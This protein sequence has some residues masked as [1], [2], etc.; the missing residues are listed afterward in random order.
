MI[1]GSFLTR[2]PGI[3][4]RH[5]LDTSDASS[6][7]SEALRLP[8]S[9]HPGGTTPSWLRPATL[10]GSRRRLVDD[11][12]RSAPNLP[13]ADLAPTASE[14]PSPEGPETLILGATGYVGSC[15]AEALL[16]K[17]ARLRLAGRR[18]GDLERRFPA[19]DVVFSDAMDPTTLRPALRG[20]RTAYYLIHSM[21][22]AKQG[23][24]ERDRHAA[25]NFASAA[26]EAGVE[27]IIYLGGL[28]DPEDDLSHH[29]ASRHETGEMLAEGSTPVLEFRAGIIIGSGS[30]S[31]RMLADLVKRLPVMVTPRWVKT[32]AQPIGIDDVVQYLMAGRAARLEEHHVVV[33]IG[34]ADITSY[35]DL[36]RRFAK[37]RGR[38]EP[39]VISVPVLTPRLSSLWCGLV[40]SVPTSIAR[41]LIDGL[42]NEVVVR[43][44]L[45]SEL[46][47]D[48]RPIG[49]DEAVQ[50]AISGEA[51]H[52]PMNSD[53]P[54]RG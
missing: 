30:A 29:L 10:H 8:L 37:V 50:R 40:T 24:E 35:R 52:L 14:Q 49:F 41:P 21:G 34:G 25:E 43:D 53:R 18:T 4:W 46:F 23:F 7:N 31:Y 11:V 33:E 22:E 6:K 20:I 51:Q 48:V 42:R 2:Q 32:R 12:R 1:V 19:A 13:A 9:T 44:G 16:A 45:A 3:H 54:S 27:R 39:V 17:S 28:G 5:G 15:L 47:P 26:A 38:R 36:M